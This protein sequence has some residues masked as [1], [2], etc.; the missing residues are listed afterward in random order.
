M[1]IKGG[2][3]CGALRFQLEGAVSGF[4]F[5]HCTHCQ[6]STGS[7][8]GST[9]FFKDANLLWE[10]GEELKSEYLIEGTRFGKCFC[11]L[12]GCPLPRVVDSVNKVVQVPAGCLDG[13]QAFEP[14]AHIFTD[15]KK[16]WE[17]KLVGLAAFCG[18]PE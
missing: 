12:C 14:T 8:H 9:L 11:S 3:L 7:A 2:C 18:S 17:D 15:S 13:D 1:Q 4:Y 5:C 6:K 10:K 16:C